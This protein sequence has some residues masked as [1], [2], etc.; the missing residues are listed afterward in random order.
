M[1]RSR[2][3]VGSIT[4][5]CGSMF[6]GKTEE[7]IRLV[8]RAM[9]ARKKVQVFKS[10]LDTR[11]ETTVIRTHDGVCFN[12]LAVANA[13]ML[14]AM[15][16]P[17]TQV[18]GIEEVQFFDEAILSL[19]QRLADRGVEVIVAGLD[20]DFRG[21]PFG[22][23]PTLMAIADH[24]LKLHAIC[25]VCGREASRT[26]RLVDGRPADWN[27]PTI[28]IGA[29]EA[30]E[31][32]C[33]RCH[34]VRNRPRDVHDGTV[35]GGARRSR[36]GTTGVRNGQSAPASEAVAPQHSTQLDMFTSNEVS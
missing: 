2:E 7:L 9:H 33:R 23:M 12:A 21:M 19:L 28:L 4:V 14:E 10:A 20:Q 31:A 25:K 11:C 1:R 32:R 16:E 27:E 15:I 3:P 17:D 35:A 6:S 29:E 24:V 13:R 26:Q 22:F 18:V 8:R 30:Y 5:I 36:G 34:V